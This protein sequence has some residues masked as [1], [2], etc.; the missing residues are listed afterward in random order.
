M[1]GRTVIM[2]RV[3]N[4]L[5]ALKVARAK[6]PGMYA[7]GGSL[8]LRV[9]EGGSKQWVFR[10]VTNG[11]LRDMGLGP[12]HTLGLAEA[13]EKALE[14][15]K[16]RLEG[17]D[18]IERKRALV[19]SLRAANAKAMSFQQCA[20]AYIAS[21]EAGW[22]NPKHR[23][24]WRNTL[25]QHVYPAIGSLPVAAIDTALVMKVIEPL[26]TTIPET[27]S[28][29]RGRI[30]AVLDWARVQRLSRRREPRALAWAPRSPVA[31]T[32]R[33]SAR[34]STLR[35]CP[36]ARSAPSWRRCASKTA[37]QRAAWNSSC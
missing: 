1:G 26:W 33:R 9:A 12:T 36:M 25:E 3:H 7:D 13:R 31:G 2:T 19:G 4:R 24:Q 11:R 14:A 28:R 18:P 22:S 30:E 27:A 32:Q 29:V 17:I 10:Y 34:S 5:T 37:C 8:Y 35:H 21:H 15:R 16:L 6:R 23:G 20:A